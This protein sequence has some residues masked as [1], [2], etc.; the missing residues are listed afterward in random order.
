MSHAYIYIMHACASYVVIFILAIDVGA[1]Y[2]DVCFIAA[3]GI[4]LV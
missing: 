3:C 1:L 2:L 4:L